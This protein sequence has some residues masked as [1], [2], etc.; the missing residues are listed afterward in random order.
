MLPSSGDRVGKKLC[1]GMAM[2]YRYEILQ[3]QAGV[4]LGSKSLTVL[5]MVVGISVRVEGEMRG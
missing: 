1:G 2:Q 3:T 4:S 5:G